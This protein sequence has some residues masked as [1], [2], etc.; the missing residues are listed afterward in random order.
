MDDSPQA[1][2]TVDAVAES[3]MS[4]YAPFPYQSLDADGEVI[5]VNDAWTDLL[6]YEQASVNGRWFGDL[7]TAES[8]A[9]FE[10]RFP[11]F[12][13]SGR[14]SR[15]EFD[16]RRAD[17]E[18]LTIELDGTIEYDDRGDMIRTHCQFRDVTEER[19]RTADLE[20]FRRALDTANDAILLIDPDDLAIVDANETAC[21][22]LGYDRETLLGLDPGEIE[23]TITDP[24]DWREHYAELADEGSL[25]YEGEH[26]RSDG[27][28]FPVDV[29]LAMA[30]DGTVVA[31][32]RDVT[33]RRAR[34]RE[35]AE[36]E[37]RYRS[38]AE[39]L[40]TA[41]VATFILDDEFS[42]AWVNRAVAD[43][44]GLPKERVEG[45][46][47]ETLIRTEMV[48]IFEDGEAFAETVLASYADNSSVESFEC[49]VLPGEDRAERWLLHWSTPVESGEYAG[50]RIEHYTDI[51]DRVDS[52]RRIEAQRDSLRL[53]NQVVRHDIRNDLQQIMA[54][55]EL[56]ADEATDERAAYAERLLD[57][58]DHAIELTVTAR[59]VADVVLTATEQREPVDLQDVLAHEVDDVR[60]AYPGAAITVEGSL[61]AASVEADEM[62]GSLFRNVLKNAVQHSDKPVAE[63]T[64]SAT[65]AE[66]TVTVRIADNGPGIPAEVVADVVGEGDRRL[67][68]EAGGIGLYLV[69]TLLDRYGGAIDIETNE[70]EGTVVVLELPRVD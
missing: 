42:V 6:G 11:E 69:R 34:E 58:T 48:D 22:R 36:S 56:L 35:L 52:E 57:S 31:V 63:V 66:E 15:A 67:G 51:T 46:D 24:A 40:D 7:L 54:Y 53:L 17:G 14:V 59:D 27:S 19:Q 29:E 37:A 41:G 50:G 20:R 26:R 18:P 4:A 38:L 47:K 44:F 13:D 10:R 43:F 1:G 12:V 64:V 25:T 30:E 3:A 33:D 55:G 9:D 61:P 32:A 45:A 8:A 60:T 23:T 62:L 49:H 39:A 5:A 16:I 68:S 28:T 65:A 21:R 2:D 70:P